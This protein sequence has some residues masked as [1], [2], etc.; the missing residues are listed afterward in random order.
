MAPSRGGGGCKDRRLQRRPQPTSL[1]PDWHFARLTHTAL[2]IPSFCRLRDDTTSDPRVLAHLEAENCYAEQQLQASGPVSACCCPLLFGSCAGRLDLAL[3][4]APIGACARAPD[5]QRR[6]LNTAGRPG[7]RACALHTCIHATHAL[8]RQ[9]LTARAVRGRHAG[10]RRGRLPVPPTP[11]PLSS[12]FPP[13][14]RAPPRPCPCQPLP[15]STAAAKPLPRGPPVGS[16]QRLC[17]PRCC[18]ACR[19]QRPTRHGPR[20][21]PARRAWGL[22]AAP[23]RLHRRR[24]RRAAAGGGTSGFRARGRPTGR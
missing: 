18:V 12:H 14:P 24:H 23:P 4:A 20:P 11:T 17:W 7:L 15:M 19:R 22:Q 13:R 3:P 6:P 2:P 16:W 10:S 8:L 21:P 9:K 5:Y 1:Q